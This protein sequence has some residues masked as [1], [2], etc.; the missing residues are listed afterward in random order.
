[1]KAT[2]F[3]GTVWGRNLDEEV[4]AGL[5][6]PL[7]I[8]IHLV[9]DAVGRDARMEHHLHVLLMLGHDL[10]D[11]RQRAQPRPNLAIQGVSGVWK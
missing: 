5:H 11:S 2:K 4:N 10:R 6:R 8:G 9:A 3:K 7:P 1:M